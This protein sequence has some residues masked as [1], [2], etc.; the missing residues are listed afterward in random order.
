MT[1]QRESGHKCVL[2]WTIRLQKTSNLFNLL[3]GRKSSKINDDF[4]KDYLNDYDNT[5][6]RFFIENYDA[7]FHFYQSDERPYLKSYILSVTQCKNLLRYENLSFFSTDALVYKHICQLLSQAGIQFCL[8][9]DC[10]GKNIF[11]ALNR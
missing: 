9:T 5:K 8:E 4:V 2:R 10:W 7:T 6:E 1:I 3:L 11:V